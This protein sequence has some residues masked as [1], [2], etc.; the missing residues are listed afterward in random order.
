MTCATCT[1][2][3][4]KWCL[5]TYCAFDILTFTSACSMTINGLINKASKHY[6]LRHHDT[7]GRQRSSEVRLKHREAGELNQR[8][9]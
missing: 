7:F 2:S 1:A 5:S 9:T 4:G 3:Q 8:H 6:L